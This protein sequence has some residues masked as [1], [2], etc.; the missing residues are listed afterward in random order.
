M[1]KTNSCAHQLDLGL[2]WRRMKL[3]RPKRCFVNHPYIFSWIEAELTGW[4]SDIFAKLSTSYTPHD[5]QIC[6]M[7]KSG[8]TARPGA[9]LDLA[10][11]A[12]VFNGV[13]RLTGA[14]EPLE[15]MHQQA[16]A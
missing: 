14:L 8:W 3:D 6:Y 16:C 7:P 13:A 1:P 10:Y 11:A 15:L 5:A 9:I 12:G 2:A 4:Q